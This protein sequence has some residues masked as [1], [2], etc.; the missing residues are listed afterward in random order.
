MLSKVLTRTNQAKKDYRWIKNLITTVLRDRSSSQP[1][2]VVANLY[3]GEWIKY[4]QDA[5]E[6]VRIRFRGGEG[7]IPRKEMGNKRVLEI[8]FIDVGQG[9]SILIQTA[10]D[11]RVLID[12]GMDKSAHSFLQWKYNLKKYMQ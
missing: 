1:K 5:G 8:Y 3:V 7:Y 10:D 6:E 4:L 2:Q 9:D 11:K 12:G